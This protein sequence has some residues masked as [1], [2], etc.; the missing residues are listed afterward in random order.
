MHIPFCRGYLPPY[1]PFFLATSL[2]NLSASL[3]ASHFSHP[4]RLTSSSTTKSLTRNNLT[5]GHS[6]T[7]PNHPILL[8]TST[9]PNHPTPHPT[10]T[11]HPANT[12][13]PV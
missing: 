4:A 1:S 7:A 6:N 12:W 10:P 9:T 2:L 3:L 13:P 11:P 5:T 8:T